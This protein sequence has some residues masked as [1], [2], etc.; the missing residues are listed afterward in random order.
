LYRGDD[1][2]LACQRHL[3][4][5]NTHPFM[6]APIIG[7]S[8]ALEEERSRQGTAAMDVQ[9]FKGMIM[10]PYAAMGDAF[11]WGGLRPL[12]AAFAI[13]VAV[14]G[15]WWAPLLFLL[16]FNPPHLYARIGGLLGGYS[17]GLGM[18]QIVRRYQLPDLAMR[19]KEATAVLLGGVSAVL[20]S[21]ALQ[22]EGIPS[23]WGLCAIPIVALLG[24]LGRQGVSNLILILLTSALLLVLA[25]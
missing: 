10:A 7:T 24:W 11:F 23:G 25:R 15:Y 13:V 14:A 3:E 2:T 17:R 8:L 6:A 9:A 5:F 22:G 16:L 21:G 1:L 19:C 4:Y 20:V 18:I 12:A